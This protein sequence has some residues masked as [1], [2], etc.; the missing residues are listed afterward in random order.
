M[1]IKTPDNPANIDLMDLFAQAQAD[2]EEEAKGKTLGQIEADYEAKHGRPLPS[3]EAWKAEQDEALDRAKLARV[4]AR[5]DARR[6]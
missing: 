2:L 5:K 1:A 4:R 3:Y 6:R